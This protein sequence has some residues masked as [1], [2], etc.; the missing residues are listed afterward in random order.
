VN[1]LDVPYYLG[2]AY[3][4]SGL[5]KDAEQ[6]YRFV[7]DAL[8]RI[9]G[10]QEEKE[11]R[12]FEGLPSRESVQLRLA[13]VKAAT[14]NWAEAQKLLGQIPEAKLADDRERVEHR[15]LEAQVMEGRGDLSGA[16]K[17][18]QNL[19]NGWKGQPLLLMPVQQK[20]GEIRMEQKDWTGA[21]KAFEAIVTAKANGVE[22][23][24]D[25]W[26]RNLRSRGDLNM[27]QDKEL[28]AAEVYQQLL[29]EFEQK[30]PLGSVRYKLGQI[31]FKKGDI[32][33]AQKVWA[34]L[35]GERNQIY[36]KLAQ[37]KVNQ[38]QWQDEYKRYIKRIPAMTQT[39]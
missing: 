39:E 16:E 4:Q 2:L 37:E 12:V 29:D 18:L 14:R 8:H 26:A 11:R 1:R 7:D 5:L 15:A 33:N 38:A 23:P 10:Q 36:K 35:D 20:L 13:A 6:N 17:A 32:K 9:A 27:E 28:A 24:E 19:V 25:V 3:E 31:F 21:A 30:R 22:V 34:G